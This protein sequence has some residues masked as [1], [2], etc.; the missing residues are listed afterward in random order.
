MKL[1]A[2]IALATILTVIITGFNVV[3]L[4][5]GLVTGEEALDDFERYR[6]DYCYLYLD[7]ENIE[8]GTHNRLSN[9]DYDLGL[10]LK[11]TEFRYPLPKTNAFDDSPVVVLPYNYVSSPSNHRL[12]GVNEINVPDGQSKYEIIFDNLQERVGLLRMW[13]TDS[14]TRFY[15]GDGNLLAEHTNTTNQEFVGYIAQYENLQTWVERIEFDG[16]ATEPDDEYN[17]LYQVG[18]VDN[19][20][21][22]KPSLVAKIDAPARVKVDDDLKI[23]FIITNLGNYAQNEIKIEL[24]FFSQTQNEDVVIELIRNFEPNEIKN[25]E[26]TLPIITKTDKTESISISVFSPYL[27][28]V[29][30]DIS[31]YEII[32]SGC[33][34]FIPNALEL[35]LFHPET[36]GN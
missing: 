30:S 20:Y 5:P 29:A 9:M 18:E 25:I 6:E 32:N 8:T 1:P 21:Y 24:K 31:N 33:L 7:F 28:L 34:R 17:K 10:E 36:F 22:T 35:L 12:M 4:E 26:Y 16:I 27:E 11:T 15:N 19:L 3:A 14:I 13:T 2:I 23:K